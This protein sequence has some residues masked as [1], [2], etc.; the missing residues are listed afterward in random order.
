M[1]KLILVASGLMLSTLA[2]L[3]AWAADLCTL[4]ADA[5]SREVLVAE[6]DCE[7]RVTPAS[8][9]KLPLAV[10]AFDAGVITGPHEPVLSFRDGDPDW[11]VD[12][13]K[14]TDPAAWMKNSVLWYSQRLTAEMGAET[15]S[16]YA[17]NFGYGNADFSGDPG[18]DN[19][20][21]RAWV[22][23]SLL[24]SPIEQAGFLAA[25][26]EGQL[27]VSITAMTGAMGLAESAGEVD[28]WR[29]R[30]KTGSAFPR[31]ADRSFDYSRGWGWYV[32]WAERDD[33][34]LVFARL[35]QDSERHDR[36][37]GLRARDALLAE[38]PALIAQAGL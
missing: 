26:V 11:G 12:W 36:T 21:E 7:S 19:G 34:I 2:A 30:G 28:N 27:P 9:F 25:L 10:M 31:N 3:P 18:Y 1:L 32:G 38:W 35:I 17:R 13:E 37:A 6:G 14:D 20:L 4:V 8:T 24:V 23:S 5:E 33:R 29:I 22:A 15:L 16:A